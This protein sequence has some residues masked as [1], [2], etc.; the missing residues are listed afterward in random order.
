MLGS[1]V[2]T[3]ATC[4]Y[5]YCVIRAHTHTHT[6]ALHHI[7]HIN[8]P[9][10]SSLSLAGERGLRLLLDMRTIIGR[11][12]INCEAITRALSRSLFVARRTSYVRQSCMQCGQ[13]VNH[14]P[15]EIIQKLLEKY[16]KDP[17]KCAAAVAAE[18]HNIYG[19]SIEL[20]PLT[21]HNHNSIIG[22]QYYYCAGH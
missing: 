1:D 5:Y 17:E 15:N 21:V 7:R 6:H 18:P 11:G 4:V 14:F 22:D 13:T 10:S 3:R 12:R 9:T 19:C 16:L 2:H 8:G 20:R